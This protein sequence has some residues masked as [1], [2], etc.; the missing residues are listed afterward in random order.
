M[1]K[2]DTGAAAA[3]GFGAAFLLAGIALLLQEID[4]LTLRWSYVLP[5]ILITAGAVVVF[6][7]LI[8]AHRSRTG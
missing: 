5:F 3:A 4:L 8:G 2:Q 7:G 1:S 6:S